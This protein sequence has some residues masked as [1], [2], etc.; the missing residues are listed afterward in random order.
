M[1]HAKCHHR[2]VYWTML[3][4]CIDSMCHALIK[5]YCKDD[6]LLYNQ[7]KDGT[8]GGNIKLCSEIYFFA[9]EGCCTGGNLSISV[10]VLSMC[11]VTEIVVVMVKCFQQ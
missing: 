8:S 7:Y 2:T 6:V 3:W 10:G 9:Y 1:S 11:I 4:A 5:G